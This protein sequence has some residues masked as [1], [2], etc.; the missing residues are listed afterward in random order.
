MKT[1]FYLIIV[2]TFISCNSDNFYETDRIILTDKTK[3][4]I[5]DKFE[6]KL[7]ISPHNEKKE[8]RVNEN[9]KNLEISFSL[10]NDQKNIQNEDWSLNS[11]EFLKETKINKILISKKNPF[12][13]IFQGKITEKENLVELNIAEL[14]LTAQFDKAKLSNGSLIRIH[15]F[16]NPIEP[17]FGA[18]LEEYFEPVE[19]KIITDK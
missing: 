2:L 1:I 7:T 16:C 14:N 12:V 6:I 15:G 11:G 4:K 18:S 5:D 9:F 3:Y 19:I 8:I 13:K 10:V 17:E